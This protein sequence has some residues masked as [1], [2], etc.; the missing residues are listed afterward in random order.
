M[1]KIVLKMMA[2]LLIFYVFPKTELSTSWVK[3]AIIQNTF[4]GRNTCFHI[5][6]IEDKCA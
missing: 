6:K 3:I 2:Y 4:S 5:E 1:G